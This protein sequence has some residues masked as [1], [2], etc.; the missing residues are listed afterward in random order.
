MGIQVADDA[1]LEQVRKQFVGSFKTQMSDSALQGL[2]RLFKLNILSLA[3]VDDPLL[4]LAGPGVWSLR[5]QPSRRPTSCS[6]ALSS[7]CWTMSR[8][9][10]W[11]VESVEFFAPPGFVSSFSF[12]ARP[13]LFASSISI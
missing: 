12:W 10:L 3:A 2:T 13:L 7:V 6:S 5:L 11:K 4:G 1:P 8:A 9:E